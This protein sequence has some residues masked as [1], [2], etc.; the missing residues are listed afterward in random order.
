LA[1]LIGQTLGQ[2][3]VTELL[4]QGG[5]ATVYKAHQAS[6]DRYVAIKVLPPHAALDDQFVER[7]QLE[8]KTIGSLQHPHILPLYDYGTQD[9]ILY[10]VMAYVDAGSLEDI[11]EDRENLSVRRIEKILREIASALDYANRRGVIHRDVKPANILIDGEGHAL[12]ADFGIVKMMGNDQNLTGTGVVGTPAYIAPEQG[13]GETDIDGRADLYSLA[14]V[15]YQMFSGVQPYRADTMMKV[16]LQHI[17]DPVPSLVSIVP[18]L[19]AAVDVVMHKA[20][21]KK[22]DDRY[23]TAVEFAEAITHALHS[24]EESLLVAKAE[25]P[26][27]QRSP[28]QQVTRVFD[29]PVDAEVSENQPNP[30]IVVQQTTNPLLFM[31][32]FGIIALVIVVVAIIL[33][34]QQNQNTAIAANATETS[35]VVTENVSP[36]DVPVPEVVPT[37][38][39]FGEM[40]FNT[41][42]AMGDTINLQLIGVA[43]P[44]DNNSYVVWLKNT[45]TDDVINIGKIVVDA[46]GQGILIYTDEE[47]RMLPSLYN[48]IV[49]TE[50]ATTD[51]ELP[52][53][54]I[55]YDGEVPVELTHALY[56]I[57]VSS[58]DGFN[59]EGLF[60]GVVEE[61]STAQSHASLAASASSVGSMKSHAEHTLNI[62]NGSNEDYDGNGNPQNPGRGVGMFFFLDKIDKLLLDVVQRDNM[63]IYVQQNADFILVCTTNVHDWANRVNELE[64]ELIAADSLESVVEQSAETEQIAGAMTAGIDLN[65]NG[66]IDAFE[67][68]CGLD[69][70]PAFGIQVGNI[71][72]VASE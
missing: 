37:V 1:S 36:T 72:I 23:S 64:L 21:A 47:Q 54:D 71:D 7:F 38:E 5:M 29:P 52:E 40:R 19:P 31:G 53:G 39:T 14:C 43:P 10:L 17:T 22:P 59:E 60:A 67:G 4:G 35:V 51:S 50:E 24:S 32:L 69:Q 30:T 41:T 25:V 34:G 15:V 42:D 12:L 68:E 49:I 48:N 18:D 13:Q 6:I 16:M 62:I 27:D 58:V 9:D 28:G 44:P 57:F 70:I 55:A 45:A 66:R 26:L 63:S 8:A 3:E 33:V 65:D 11:I 2:Y 46:T 61:T 56:E 20:M